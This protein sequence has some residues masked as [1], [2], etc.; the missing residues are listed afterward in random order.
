MIL[1]EFINKG[2]KIQPFSFI[3]GLK[4]DNKRNNGNEF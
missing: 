4:N 1:N 2:L 3:G